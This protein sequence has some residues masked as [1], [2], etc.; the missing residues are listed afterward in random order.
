MKSVKYTV[1]TKSLNR[2]SLKDLHFQGGHR[3]SEDKFAEK[4]I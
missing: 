1:S 3:K 2:L 4:K